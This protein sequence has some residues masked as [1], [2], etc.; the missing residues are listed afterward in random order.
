MEELIQ[1]GLKS[2]LTLFR[3]RV[4]TQFKRYDLR[5]YVDDPSYADVG[6]IEVQQAETLLAKIGIKATRGDAVSV[7]N[8]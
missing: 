1:A 4:K 2:R 8:L 3:F 5:A 7:S 6:S